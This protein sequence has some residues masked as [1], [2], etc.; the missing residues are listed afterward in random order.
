MNC[1]NCG[2]NRI[3]KRGFTEKGDQLY[4]CVDKKHP[5][6]K[7]RYFTV[8]VEEYN[9][10]TSSFTQTDD[11][12]HVVCDTRRVLSQDDI[13]EQF[14]IDI[15]L[16]Q[17][18]SFTVKTS[19]GYRKDR[20]VSWHVTDGEVTSGHVED[21]GKMLIVPMYHVS[22]EL[23]KR[24]E[25]TQKVV[26]DIFENLKNKNLSPI[27]VT[28]S[29]SDKNGVYVIVPVADL[30]LGLSTTKNVEGN[31]YNM[32]LAEQ[33]FY[34]VIS[35][36][37]SRLKGKKVKEIIF[38]VGN[39][40][41]NSDNLQNTTEHGTPQDTNTSW[42][43]LIDKAVELIIKG[44]NSLLEISNVKIINVPSNHDRHSMYGVMKAVEQ[45]FKDSKNVVIDN[46]PI[47]TKYTMV[48]KLLLA[49]THDI[50][51]K[52]ALDVVTTDAKELWSSSTH[53]IWL[54]GHLHKAMQYEQRG[55]MEIYRLP[56]VSGNSRWSAE[57]HYVQSEKR[58][59]LFVVDEND[60]VL[61]IMN[62]VVK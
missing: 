53:V 61:D 9:E 4:Q 46:R 62:I 55:V 18:K 29:Q 23:I 56:T 30:H 54:L 38:L 31:D 28:S 16:W 57:K 20:K 7:K 33:Y 19:E 48:G 24:R 13:I 25:L 37:K 5:D 44:T 35:Q 15:A 34:D 12:I 60:G 1:P 36:A 40:F 2:S 32:E 47:Y 45:Y 6:D 21:T 41:L 49:L 51:V 3:Q 11:S 17:I 10:E 39:D 26:D 14:N 59:Q 52:R 22:L 43:Y 42:F 8:K 58:T 50:D 27:K